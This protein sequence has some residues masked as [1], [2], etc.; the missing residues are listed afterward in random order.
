MSQHSSTTS[1]ELQ[2]SRLLRTV[3]NGLLQS[4]LCI[5]W[6]TKIALLVAEPEEFVQRHMEMMVTDGSGKFMDVVTP[7]VT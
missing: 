5:L 7:A 2:I 6:L 4:I 1:A 3:R